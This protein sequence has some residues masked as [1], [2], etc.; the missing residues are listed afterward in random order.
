MA[1]STNCSVCADEGRVDEDLDPSTPCSALGTCAQQ[2][3]QGFEDADCDA[4]TPCTECAAGQYSSGG[5][6]DESDGS[7]TKCQPCPAG[8][9]APQ[10]SLPAVCEGCAPGFAD[11]D[12]NSWTACAECSAGKFT[13]DA[14]GQ[15]FVSGDASQCVACPPGRVD[16]DTTSSTACFQCSA[17]KYNELIGSTEADDCRECAAGRWS[18]S[19][20]SARCEACPDNTYRGDGDDGC[21]ACDE[22]EGERCDGQGTEAP[23]AGPGFFVGMMNANGSQAIVKCRPPRAC[24]GTCGADVRASLIA[25]LDATNDT[26]LEYSDC[27]G[28]RG[29]E[30]CSPGYEGPR[31]S[32]CTPITIGGTC[33]DDDPNGYYRLDGRC[34]VRRGLCCAQH[35]QLTTLILVCLPAVPM[36]RVRPVVDGRSCDRALRSHGSSGG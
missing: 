2:C 9:Y 29:Q 16:N 6:F 26:D 27:P 36:Q 12:A 33:S 1:G 10:G 34:E 18:W 5:V 11:T 28:G 32:Q 31:C 20:G 8:S 24:F 35:C 13:A 25:A 17:G 4:S 23:S 30:L 22:G 15:H 3:S 19:D 7:T 21:Q 14:T